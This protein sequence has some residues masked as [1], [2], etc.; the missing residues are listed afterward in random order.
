MKDYLSYTVE[1]FATDESYLRYYF[2]EDENDIA[3][4][5]AWIG[6]HPEKLDVVISANNYIDAFS[7]R[8]S[9]AELQKEQLRF[10]QSLQDLAAKEEPAITW[11]ETVNPS[12]PEQ[13]ETLDYPARPRK[14]RGLV[15]TTLIV[16]SGIGLFYLG[17][18]KNKTSYAE[19]GTG[20]LALVEKYVPKGE[21]A[22]IILP[23]GSEVELNADS[24]LIYPTQFTGATRELQL[25]GEAFF[26]VK[27][28]SLHPFHVVS[29]N[30]AITVLGT[31][32]N[33]QC[34][35]D[36]SKTRVALVTGKV[37]LDRIVDPVNKKTLGE[38]MILLPA[39]LGVFDK[40]DLSLEKKKYDLNE[41]TGW[42]QGIVVFND[43]DFNEIADRLNK[44]YNIHLVNKSHKTQF[45]F[46]GTFTNHSAEEIVKIICLS[47]KL[48]YTINGNVI[49]IH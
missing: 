6:L 29:P 31:S 12:N 3:F 39:E 20:K 11:S 33:M 36:R 48:S 25:T 28:D 45:K 7:A 47:K 23:D 24:K 40:Q 30:L 14:K 21:R 34:Y 9:E 16:L 44:V 17:I 2:K 42:R 41:E 19:D 38:S 37:K 26:R 32:F 22:T 18:R 8:L 49:T 27:K 10:A 4:W 13:E 15:I 1:D 5:T 46:K 35:P 43:A